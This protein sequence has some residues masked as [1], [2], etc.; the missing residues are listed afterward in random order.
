MFFGMLIIGVTCL[1]VLT[2]SPLSLTLPCLWT[3]VFDVVN[4][5]INL[6]NMEDKNMKEIE[7]EEKQ[8][9][10]RDRGWNGQTH[11]VLGE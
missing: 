6:N 4:L 9:L 2:S 1:G 5:F 8:L 11:S 3:M 10:Y 7:Y